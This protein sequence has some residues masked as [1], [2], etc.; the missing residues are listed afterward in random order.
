MLRGYERT[1]QSANHP[2]AKGVSFKINYPTSWKAIEG[3]RP[4]IITKFIS[5]NGR[6]FESV[7]LTVKE[8]PIP[9][10]KRIT[11]TEIREAF[12]EDTLKVM[13]PKGARFI[14]SA[15]IKLDGLPGAMMHY[16][17]SGQRLDMVLQTRNLSFVV[18]FKNKLIF[19]VCGVAALNPNALELE[20]R[21]K[22]REPLFRLI[23]NSLVVQSRW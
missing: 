15:R 16:D 8:L 1:F 20:A 12:S 19:I 21:F 23:A 14:S 5:E 9:E 22:H 4:N 3:E 7:M 6:G 17:I 11:E 13:L 2:K 10:Q 18:L